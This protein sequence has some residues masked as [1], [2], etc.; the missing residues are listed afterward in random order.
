MSSVQQLQQQRQQVLA[1]IA[2]LEQV[3]RGSLT[4][5]MVEKVGPDGRHHQRGPYPLYTFKEGGRTVSRRLTDRA[6]IPLYRQQIQ[7]GRR[8]QELTAQLL[9]L[10]EA[11]SD[12]TVRGTAEKKTSKPKSRSTSKPAA[13]SIN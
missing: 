6:Q 10:G 2:Q 8:F 7:Q 9:R 4:E 5:Q 12:Q 1:E 11:L 3:R 13:L